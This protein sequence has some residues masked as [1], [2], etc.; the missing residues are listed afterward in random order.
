MKDLVEQKTLMGSMEFAGTALHTGA[1]TSVR[2][3]PGAPDSGY[4]FRRLDV[5]GA[6]E[7]EASVHNIS[8]TLLA[9][10]LGLNGTSVK[11]VEHILSAMAGS[12]VDNAVIEVDG[13]EIPIMDGSA[14]PFV[15]GIE[16]VG[17]AGQGVPKRMLRIKE[18][19]V[20]GNGDASAALS[21]SDFFRISFRIAFDHPAVG[22]QELDFLYS[23]EAYRRDIAFARTFGF[24]RDVERLQEKGLAL[25]GSFDN[26]VVV[27]DEGVMNEGGLRAPDEFVRHKILDTIGDLSLLGIP[28]LGHYQGHKAGHA[29]NRL[30][31]QE[32]LQHPER[33]ELVCL[34]EIAQE[35]VVLH[36]IGKMVEIGVSATL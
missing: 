15:Q 28:I 34:E 25:G 35:K 1:D 29:V 10:S 26:A 20:A 24:Y 6:P 23:P 13:D 17:L 16:I 36:P 30:L 27:G 32:V 21:P 11:T 12:G 18:E 4:R 2:V 5:P 7:V 8:D 19:I 31:M 14:A 3:I 9:T 22:V 33:W